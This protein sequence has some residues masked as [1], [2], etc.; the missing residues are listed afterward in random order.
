MSVSPPQPRATEGQTAAATVV[1]AAKNAYKDD[2]DNESVASSTDQ[3][4]SEIWI[5]LANNLVWDLKDVDLTQN[6]DMLVEQLEEFSIRFGN[7]NPNEDHLRMMSIV[8]RHA[9]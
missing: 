7:E 3:S 8:Y 4:Y 1:N 5:V 6:G 9:R 2:S